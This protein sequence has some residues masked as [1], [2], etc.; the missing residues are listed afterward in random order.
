MEV[1]RNRA[2][3][4]MNN[5]DCVNWQKKRVIDEILRGTINTPAEL[6]ATRGNKCKADAKRFET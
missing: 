4:N 3:N 6:K 5:V 1:I 2:K